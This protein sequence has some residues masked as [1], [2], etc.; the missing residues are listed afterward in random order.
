MTERYLVTGCAGFIASKVADLLLEAGHEVVGIDNVN[1]A[2]DP[3]LKRWRLEQL[4]GRPDFS[5]HETDIT[6]LRAMERV[7]QK[8]DGRPASAPPSS[9]PFAAVVNL[10]ARASM[11][12]LGG[13][14][15][16]LL[17]GQLYRHTQPAGDVPADGRAEVRARLDLQPVREAQPDA[18]PRKRRHEPAAVALRGLEKAAETLAFSY[19]HL[20]GIDVS[21]PRYF[22]VYGPA[23]RPDMS[24]FR[25]IRRIAEGEPIMVMGDGSQSRDFTFIDNIARGTIAAIRPL[26]YEI[27]NLGGD[28][29]VRLDAVIDQIVQLTGGRLQ[30]D[31]RPL[32]PADVPA[33]RAD[34]SKA[35]RLLDWRPQVGIEEG[36]RRSVEWYRDNREF[37]RQLDLGDPRKTKAFLLWKGEAAFRHSERQRRI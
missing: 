30:I 32:H 21:I 33:T 22:T 25:F 11:S 36:L 12:P 17:P 13:K 9:P 5:F 37:A 26:G 35:A 1:D 10:A 4:R 2:Y 16:D 6:D 7:F 8:G 20:H 15:L 28:R 3:R 23:G 34:L 14:S 18:V 29:Q 27:I 24:V 31:R 19:H